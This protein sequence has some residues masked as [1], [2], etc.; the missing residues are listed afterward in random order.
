MQDQ[1]TV[2]LPMSTPAMLL[3]SITVSQQRSPSI[4]LGDSDRVTEK[5][6]WSA[7]PRVLMALPLPG[8]HERTQRRIGK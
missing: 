7:H 6:G 3:D 5:H 4:E 2:A 8:V 1:L